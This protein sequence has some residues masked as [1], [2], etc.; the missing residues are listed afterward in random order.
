M[1]M[2]AIRRRWTAADV[3]VL[4]DESRA[5]PRY[6]LIAGELVVTPAPGSAHQ[7]AVLEIAILLA[8]YVD[9]DSLGVAVTSPADLELRPGTITQPDVFVIPADTRIAGEVLQWPDV[10]GLLLAVEVLS[11]SSVRVDRVE[12]RDFYL[13]SGVAEYWIVDLD[14]RAVERWTAS[15]ESP[16]IIRDRLIWH[17]SDNPLIIDLPAM[18]DRIAAKARLLP[19]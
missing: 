17:A 3:R 9:R 18:F 14:A 6:E 19:R 16:V 11:P 4:M 7:L 5:W 8:A 13:D 12:K 15:Q 2:P 10:K 1:A